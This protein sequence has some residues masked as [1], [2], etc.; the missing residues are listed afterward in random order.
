[1]VKNILFP[2]LFVFSLVGCNNDDN[3]LAPSPDLRK[4]FIPDDN[5]E[6]ALIELALDDVLDDS[7][8]TQRIEMIRVLD[9]SN[10]E[11][12]IRDLTGIK[13]FINLRV[14]NFGANLIF[15]IDIS[16]LIYLEELY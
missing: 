9:I 11:V 8:M 4:T 15:E 1:M 6:Q 12:P 10:R 2:L 16:N 13:D 14:L 3:E 7:V 5:F